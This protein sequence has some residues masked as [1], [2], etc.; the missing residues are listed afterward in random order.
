[1]THQRDRKQVKGR[2]IDFEAIF[3]RI[4]DGETL[5]GVCRDFDIPE[6]TVRLRI[7][8]SKELSELHRRARELQ[9]ESW[10]DEMVEEANKATPDDWQSQRLRIHTKQWLMSRN[11]VARFGDKVQSEISGSG[12]VQLCWAKEEKPEGAS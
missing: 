6:A 4:A 7:L 10:A 12:T 2:K 1:M 3:G 8:K 11:H 5:K 9:A